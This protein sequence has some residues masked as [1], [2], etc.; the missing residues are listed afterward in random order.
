[1]IGSEGIVRRLP[2]ALDAEET[3]LLERSAAILNAAYQPLVGQSDHVPGGTALGAPD[4]TV[5]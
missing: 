4:P 3:A 1:V 2:L 5:D